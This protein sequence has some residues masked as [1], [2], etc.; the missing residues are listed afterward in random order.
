M[1][2]GVVFCTQTQGGIRDA[3][4]ADDSGAARHD[5]VVGWRS[6]CKDGALWR[7]PCKL[8]IGDGKLVHSL[9]LLDTQL[10]YLH[11]TRM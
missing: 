1:F 8:A 11:V 3:R 4:R 5:E 10:R 2:L 6:H 9:Q 7:L